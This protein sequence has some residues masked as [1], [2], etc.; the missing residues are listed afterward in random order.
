MGF[1]RVKATIGVVV[2]AATILRQTNLYTFPSLLSAVVCSIV[3]HQN[4]NAYV[5]KGL[6]N[7][8]IANTLYLLTAL[9]FFGRSI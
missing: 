1:Q 9:M 6:T 3:G 8:V 4:K 2:I 5:I 7:T